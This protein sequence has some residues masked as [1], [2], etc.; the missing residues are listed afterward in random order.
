MKHGIQ[1]GICGMENEIKKNGKWNTEGVDSDSG[2][3]MRM[4]CGMKN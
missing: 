4:E 2:T 3:G 1:N